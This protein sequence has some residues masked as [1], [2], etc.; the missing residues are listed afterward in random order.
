MIAMDF[1]TISSVGGLISATIGATKNA[2]DL[3]KDSSD[4][5]LKDQIGDIYDALYELRERIL[6]LDE[7]NRKLKAALEEKAA[8]VGPIPP[9]GYVFAG[10]DTER[11]H[12]LCPT[13]Y[14]CKPQKIGVG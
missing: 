8:Y 3:A 12:P 6:A 14:Q 2:R 10:S 7:E 9:H 11:Q 5:A 13:C 4:N 1:S